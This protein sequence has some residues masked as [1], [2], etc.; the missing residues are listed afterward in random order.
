MDNYNPETFWKL[1]AIAGRATG[2]GPVEGQRAK[3]SEDVKT[4]SPWPKTHKE[5]ESRKKAKCK[6]F[7]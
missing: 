6:G 7:P 4:L 3:L 2:K 5:E 1:R